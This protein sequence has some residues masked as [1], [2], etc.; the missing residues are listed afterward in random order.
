MIRF[1]ILFLVLLFPYLSAAKEPY[2]TRFNTDSFWRMLVLEPAGKPL[3][4][5]PSDTVIV[6]ASNRAPG[7]DSLRF[8]SEKR[9][10]GSIS[11]YIVYIRN[12][13]WHL[14]PVAGLREALKYIPDKQ[15]DWVVYTEG[16]GKIFTTDI[17]RGF[18]LSNA[19]GVN[20]LLLDYPSIHSRYKSYRNFRFVLRNSGIA[21]KDFTPVLDTLRQ[22]REAGAAGTGSLSMLFHSM[23]NNVIRRIGQTKAR[24]VLNKEVWIDN[25]ILNAPCV[26]QRRSHRWIDSIRFAKR[27]YVHYNPEDQTLKWSRIASVRGILG[28]RP[29][30]PIAAKASYINFNTL[31]GARH[32]NFLSFSNWMIAKQE[33]VTHYHK[34]LHGD[35]VQLDDPSHYR[36]SIYRQIGYDL[37]P[38]E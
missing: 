27:I 20:V 31:C 26:P 5:V 29:V 11:Y 10:K 12:G 33:A 21:Y 25:L 14:Q 18:S 1:G 13:K 19:Y 38:S 15:K 36:K 34:L 24:Q 2:Y 35:M 17:D 30:R 28:E 37:L 6:V 16:M 3:T 4:L 9:G 8:M 32:S 7:Q 23:G 22:L